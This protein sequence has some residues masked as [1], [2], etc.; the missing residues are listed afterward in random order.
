MKTVS[1][2]SIKLLGYSSNLN[3]LVLSSLTNLYLKQPKCVESLSTLP[4][5]MLFIWVVS[6]IFWS[7]YFLIDE[8]TD[9]EQLIYSRS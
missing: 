6:L 7:K 5:I 4:S 3:C 9:L 8:K 2:W 1:Q